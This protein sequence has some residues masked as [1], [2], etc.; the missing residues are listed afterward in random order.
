MRKRKWVVDTM[1][2]DQMSKWQLRYVNI[3]T[4][5]KLLMTWGVVNYI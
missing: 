4:K 1:L 2:G 5:K 3:I